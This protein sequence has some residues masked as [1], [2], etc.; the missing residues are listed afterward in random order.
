MTAEDVRFYYD[1]IMDPKNRRRFSR[2]GF[3]FD[4]PVIV[5]SLTVS[6]RAKKSAGATSGRRL[7]HGVP[8][9]R[10]GKNFSEIR[11]DIPV[12]NGPYK[13]IVPARTA[14]EL[15]RRA[16]WWGFHKNWNRNGGNFGRSVTASWRT[17]RRLRGVQ[18][19]AISTPM[20]LH[21]LHLDEADGLPAVRSKGL[22]GEQ[23]I[24]NREPI[25]FPGNGDEPAAASLRAISGCAGRFAPLNRRLMN[26]KYMYNQYFLLNSYVPDLWPGNTI[27]V[28]RRLITKS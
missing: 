23:R 14:V 13:K 16:D 18:E 7:R 28:P 9:T 24:F 22:G 5:D 2:W 15:E 20:R 17:R 11:Y 6:I 10:G 12:V 21:V 3:C 19:G 8:G 4:R 27:R 1:V 26:E 25:G